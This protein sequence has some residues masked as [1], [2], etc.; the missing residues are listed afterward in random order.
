ME[1]SF[2]RIADSVRLPEGSRTRIR[3]QIASH[4]E[5]Q[6]ASIMKTK[7]HLLRL[8]VALIVVLALSLT[9]AAAVAVYKGRGFVFT[10]NMSQA[11]KDELVEEASI[12]YARKQID[13]D[14]TVHY[15]N[16]DGSEALVLSAEEDAAYQARLRAEHDRT[17]CESTTLVD[18]STMPVLPNAVTELAVDADGHFAAFGFENAQMVLLYPEASGGFSLQAGDTVT[19]SFDTETLC[20]LGFGSFKDGEYAGETT[21]S[22]DGFLHTFEIEA[23]GEYCFF[24]ENLSAGMCF[25]SNGAVTV[26]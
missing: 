21:V 18:L 8:A 3:A 9:A 2:K 4:R 10:E 14:G 12:V 5:K 16:S 24:L 1:Q 15:F 17:V 6:E 20:S 25:L 13:A 22:A 19:L 23:D 7:K 26:H 11:E